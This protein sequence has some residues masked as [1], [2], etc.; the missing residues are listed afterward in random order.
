MEIFISI[1][2][3]AMILA[4]FQQLSDIQ[5]LMEDLAIF[6]RFYSVFFLFS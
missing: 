3:S 2:K 6:Q 1:M 4:L 5:S